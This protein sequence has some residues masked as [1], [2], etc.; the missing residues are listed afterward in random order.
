M[1]NAAFTAKAPAAVVDKTRQRLA[2]A[3]A[4]IARL[5]QR[6]ASI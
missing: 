4:D 1:A 3:Q 5:E 6:L 2:A